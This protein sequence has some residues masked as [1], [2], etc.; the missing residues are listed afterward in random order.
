MSDILHHLVRRGVDAA[1]Q[2]YAQVQPREGENEPES[3]ELALW[4]LILLFVTF[5]LYFVVISAVSVSKPTS[6]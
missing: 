1:N 5:A 3:K 4:G 2:H 6:L